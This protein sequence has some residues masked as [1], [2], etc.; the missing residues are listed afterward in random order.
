MP[1]HVSAVPVRPC[2][3]SGQS[4]GRRRI[5]PGDLQGIGLLCNGPP[6]SRSTVP[7]SPFFF[8]DAGGPDFSIE[9]GA[10]REGLWPVAGTDEAGRGPLAGPVVAA[11]VILDPDNIPEGLNDSKKLSLSRREQ[12][13]DIILAN[14]IVSVASSGAGRIDGTDIR[15]ASLDAMR[16]AVAGLAVAPS[17]V[18]ADGRDVPPGLACVGRAV[19]KGDARSVSIAAASIVA[20]VTRDR[21][22]ARADLVFPAYGFS[23]HAGYATARHRKAIID[24]GPCP[25]HR[26][27]FRPLRR[28]DEDGENGQDVTVF[29]GF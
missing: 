17:C 13:Y 1:A 29:D 19:V 26:M 24:D 15:K 12:L 7:D 4:P 2:D 11:A 14:A 22:M 20:K 3:G 16:R 23:V 28:D 10:R 8:D 21:M 27:S 25:L 6:M 18:L 9:T 5:R